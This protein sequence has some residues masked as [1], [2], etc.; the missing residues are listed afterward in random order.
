MSRAHEVAILGCAVAVAFLVR[1][2]WGLHVLSLT[3]SGYLTAGD[4]SPTY[5]KLASQIASGVFPTVEDARWWGG[6]LYWYVLG[7]VYR[8][9]GIGN[10]RAVI[11][12]QAALGALLPAATYLIARTMFESRAVAA[13]SAALVSLLALLI[14]LCGVIG[15][16]ALY[17]PLLY[18]ALTGL[19]WIA[20]R[21]VRPVSA[22]VA[23]GVLF[24]LANI[25]R[26]EVFGYP[27]VLVAVTMFVGTRGD[28]RAVVL[29]L[30]GFLVVWTAQG[31]FNSLVYSQFVFRSAQA[32]WTFDT[33]YM[34]ISENHTLS[35]VM[36]F[37][38]FRDLLGS[39]R[40]FIEYPG[41]VTKLLVVGFVKR[42]YVFLLLPAVGVFN[43][44]TLTTSDRFH[45]FFPDLR[46]NFASLVESFSIIFVVIGLSA[47]VRARHRL[48]SAALI[49]WVGYSIFL[50]A[51]LG[52]QN[53][54]HRAVLVPIFII[55]FVE[56]IAVLLRQVY[57]ADVPRLPHRAT[58]NSSS[59]SGSFV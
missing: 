38:P 22:C 7:G 1:Y 19:I 27:V 31:V 14:Y 46:I 42:F 58:N 50:N 35:S 18:A 56:G 8:V 12:L 55:C 40:V 9:A 20:A 51:F 6:M 59:P 39:V 28:L 32:I 26:N 33:T 34:G 49:S 16:E 23:V 3:G 45:D 5:H 47:L 17:L 48:G 29:L 36:G 10:F 44:L 21:D 43:P 15:M 41:T 13:V 53:A 54:R 25:A 11:L 4:D 24:G 57:V 52:V 37:N 2:L 30:A